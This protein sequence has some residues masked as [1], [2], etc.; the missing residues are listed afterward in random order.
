[1]THEAGWAHA[2]GAFR[3]PSWL[4][5]PADPNDLVPQL[6]STT[7][8]KDDA[9][10]LTVGGVPLTD[11]VAE[12]GSPAYVLDEEDFRTRARAF[13]D[14]F[15]AYEVYYAGK[16]FL[17]TAVARWVAE[18]GL[19]LDVCS[20][21]EMA[22]A[23]RAG[24]PMERVGFHGNNKSEAE[25]RRAVRNGV[26]RIIVDS[27]TEIERL[28]RI[29]AEEGA[30]A[31]VM[32]RVTAGVEAHTHEYIA[33]AHEDQKFGFSIT[34]GAALEAVRRVAAA[35]ALELRGLHS[36]IGSQIF[37]SSGF[38]VA[39]RRVLALHAAVARELGTEMPEMD[40]GGGFGIAYTTQDDPADPARLATEMTQIVEHECRAL[41]LA[42]PAL[43]I[44]PGRAIVGPSMCTVYE[45][46]TV[47]AVS[48]D[49]GASRAYVSVDGGMSD[50]IRTALYDAD[51]SCTLA[52]RRSDADPVLGRVVG[53]HCEAGDIVVKDEF[54]PG[55]LAP[56]DLLAVPGTGAY[57][58]SMASNYNHLLRPPVIAVRD[59]ASRVLVRRETE[60]DLLATDVGDL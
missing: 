40:L 13:R 42:Q 31:R 54:L 38:E 24:F 57:C 3:G 27:F 51:Y 16:A 14:A 34:S 58:R 18:E 9:G 48:L 56:G 50:N 32:V 19:S 52:S 11:L 23:E 20:G 1:M 33:T 49:G 45:V 55:D 7:A 4:R 30:T 21:G 12:H 47:K 28:D 15:A 44:E 17:S 2:P 46:G 22:V 41:G 60:D 26:G 53:K 5:P 37:D 36:H 39:A 29:A 35:G 25:L 59:G 8:H 6:W 43:S 10:V